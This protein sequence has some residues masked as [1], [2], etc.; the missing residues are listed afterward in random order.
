MYVQA[1]LHVVN[2]SIY[3]ETPS[4]LKQIKTNCVESGILVQCQR[5]TNTFNAPSRY[6]SGNYRKH[7]LCRDISSFKSERGFNSYIISHLELKPF[8]IWADDLLSLL[9]HI[10]YLLEFYMKVLKTNMPYRWMNACFLLCWILTE[11]HKDKSVFSLDFCRFS[12]CWFYMNVYNCDIL[13]HTTKTKW[14]RCSFLYTCMC[15]FYRIVW[16]N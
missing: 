4:N 16:A 9:M 12:T 10:S 13:G 3:F 8:W 14:E 6:R 2:R 11:V 15:A 1:C 5:W 7:E